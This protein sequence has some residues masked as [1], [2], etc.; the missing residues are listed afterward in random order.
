MLFQELFPAAAE[1]AGREVD[2]VKI[3]AS[4]PASAVAPAALAAQLGQPLLS[5]RAPEP[6]DE[7]PLRGDDPRD[8]PPLRLSPGSTTTGRT[9]GGRW[10]SAT[11]TS[12]RSRPA[13]PVRRCRHPHRAE[14][15]GEDIESS[16][17]S[18]R[19]SRAMSYWEVARLRHASRGRRLP[20]QEVPCGALLE[21]LLP[22]R[23]PR[24]GARGHPPSPCSRARRPALRR[25][26]AIAIMAGLSRR[27]LRGAG[28]RARRPPAALVAAWTA[29]V[30]FFGLGRR[31]FSA[32]GPERPRRALLPGPS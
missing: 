2:R 16:R 25:R 12:A 13:A 9:D 14:L 17:G 18:T 10:S 29:N 8:G 5:H 3:R 6:A 21:A 32:R 1:R 23:E 31:C 20:G 7:R 27:P 24:D 11:A 4:S 15:A 22:A 19:T 26:L 30:I 28:V